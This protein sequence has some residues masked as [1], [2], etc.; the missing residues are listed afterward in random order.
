MISNFM[1]AGVLT[2]YV[3]DVP[4]VNKLIYTYQMTYTA[5]WER[6]EIH[7]IWYMSKRVNMVEDHTKYWFQYY[8]IRTRNLH[9]YITDVILIVASWTQIS[10]GL[11]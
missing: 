8:S 4:C 6:I 1:C 9:M 7:N 2:R 5:P 11:P 10:F 3:P